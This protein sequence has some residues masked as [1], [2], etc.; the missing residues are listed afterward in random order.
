MS[1]TVTKSDVKPGSNPKHPGNKLY[2]SLI[3]K[4][5]V[6]YVLEIDAQVKNKIAQKVYNGIGSQNP[7][8]RFLNS[9]NGLYSIK[10]EKDAIKKIKTALNENKKTI[11]EHYGRR[12]WKK[13]PQVRSQSDEHPPP[14]DKNYTN[15]LKSFKRNNSD[16]K[17]LMKKKE[18]RKKRPGPGTADSSSTKQTGLPSCFGKVGNLEPTSLDFKKLVD[19]LKRLDSDDVKGIPKKNTKSKK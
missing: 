8:G 18:N 4:Y 1:I 5:K 15:L 16:D 17:R 9:K 2:Q 19:A 13:P 3:K 6:A 14:D 7:E 12:P 11:E 10:T